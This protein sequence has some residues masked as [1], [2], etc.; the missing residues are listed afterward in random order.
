MRVTVIKPKKK[1][2]WKVYIRDNSLYPSTVWEAYYIISIPKLLDNNGTFYLKRNE[3]RA[4][5][6]KCLTPTKKN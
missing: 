3:G 5:T 6:V 1:L 4:S 2:Y